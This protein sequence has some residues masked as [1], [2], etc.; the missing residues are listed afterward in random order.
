MS[1]TINMTQGKPFKL[2]FSFALPLMFGNV[3]QQMYTVVDTAIVGQGVGLNALAALGSVD[4]LNWMMLGIAQG[5]TQ[6]CAVRVSQ[7]FGEGDYK[8]LRHL[9]GQSASLSAMIAILCT[10]IGHLGL[11]LIFRLLSV[12]DTVYSLAETYTRILFTGLPA[13]FFYNYCSTILR[14]VGDSKTPLKAMILAS[15]TNIILDCVTVFGLHW[16]IGGAAIATVFAQCLSGAICAHRIWKTPE[17][18]FA[19]TDLKTDVVTS[20]NLIKIGIPVAAK[21]IIIAIGGMVVTAVVNHF[22]MS[23]IAGFTATN[24]LFGLLEIAGISYGYAVTTYVGQNIGAGR[25]DRVKTGMRAATILTVATSF[26]IAAFMITSGRSI[27]MLFISSDVPELMTAAG[28]TAYSYL[29]ALSIF[30]P[31]LY[32]L[33]AYLAALQGLGNTVITMNSG[34]VEFFVRIVV[35]AIVGYTGYEIGIYAAE[36]GAWFGAV[37]YLVMNYNRIMKKALAREELLDY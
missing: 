29:V 19:K 15:I 32:L 24:K 11:P 8:G 34:I 14:A 26:V 36:I 25:P 33:H 37:I 12:P 7:K 23:F 28:D 13:V 5:F 16:G 18:H 21:N 27:T 9:V 6:G 1:K 30:L 3:F 35:S 17:L 2:L 4:W 22:T 10:A 31:V 20:I